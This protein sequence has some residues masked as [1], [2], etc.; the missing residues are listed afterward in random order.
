MGN[1]ILP[2]ISSFCHHGG[3]LWLCNCGIFLS[4]AFDYFVN[5]YFRSFSK[6]RSEKKESKVSDVKQEQ[7]Y[8]MQEKNQYQDRMPYNVSRLGFFQVC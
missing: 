6:K 5:L 1:V 2:G 4:L 3:G 8:N 7:L